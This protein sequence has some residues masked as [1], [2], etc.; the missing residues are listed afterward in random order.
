MRMSAESADEP[1]IGQ[2]D[3]VDRVRHLADAANPA[4]AAGSVLVPLVLTAGSYAAG[5]N[6]ALYYTHVG[7]G[8]LWFGLV[9]FIPLV[10]GP[11]LGA[12]GP[13]VAGQVGSRLTPKNSWF[14][15]SISTF[16]ILS[17]ALYAEMM[18]YLAG[19]ASPWVTVAVFL[20]VL[21]YLLGMVGP[22]RYNLKI[23]YEGA[24][25]EPDPERIG[26]L[27]QK[28]QYFGPVQICLMLGILFVMAQMGGL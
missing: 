28:M 27:K 16:T 7:L 3:F 15:G 21:V 8:A 18:G 11:V 4:F 25:P 19:P 2:Q 14:L 1:P 22:F 24:S 20:G 10:L 13:D 12:V 23:Y 26:E 6:I 17:G 5:S 9:L